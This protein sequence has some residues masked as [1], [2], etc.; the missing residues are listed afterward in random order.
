[1]E[2]YG[3]I[4]SLL[5]LEDAEGSGTWDSYRTIETLLLLEL[6][7]LLQKHFGVHRGVE[8]SLTKQW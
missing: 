4:D 1:M 8:I 2:H 3:F 7:G 6:T 5:I